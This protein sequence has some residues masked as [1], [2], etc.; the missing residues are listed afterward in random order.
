MSIRPGDL[1]ALAADLL[2]SKDE[3]R[4]RASAS[5]AYYAAYHL[6]DAIRFKLGVPV[7]GKTGMHWALVFGLM[8]Y[9]GGDAHI[10]GEVR[11]LGRILERALRIR[12]DADYKIDTDFSLIR[13]KEVNSLARSIEQAASPL[14]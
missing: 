13:A 1:L 5:R 11:I 4:L 8:R 10:Q 2:N 3:V 9:A 14:L 7:E 6:C 12:H